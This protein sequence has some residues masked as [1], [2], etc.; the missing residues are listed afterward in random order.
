MCDVTFKYYDD[1]GHAFFNDTNRL[2]TYDAE[3]AELSW[4]RTTDFLHA[5]L[6]A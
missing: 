3:L 2:G 1:A 6:G 5:A 4:Q